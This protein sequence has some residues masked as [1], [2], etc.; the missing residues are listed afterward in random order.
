[1]EGVQP[2][3]VPVGPDTRMGRNETEKEEHDAC[4]SRKEKQQAVDHPPV[5]SFAPFPSRQKQDDGEQEPTAQERR[6]EG[7]GR[8]LLFQPFDQCMRSLHQ[9]AGRLVRIGEGCGSKSLLQV[10]RQE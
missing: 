5:G 6:E 4:Q 2:D 9:L 8:F 7:V 3:D 1:M 10:E